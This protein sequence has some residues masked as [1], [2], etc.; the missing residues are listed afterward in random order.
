MRFSLLP[1]LF[2]LNELD[3]ATTVPSQTGRIHDYANVAALDAVSPSLVASCC[4]IPAG[5][6]L[7]AVRAA[8]RLQ[9]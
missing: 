1:D 6:T 7:Y 5:E 4:L 3:A 2:N 9:P 8:R